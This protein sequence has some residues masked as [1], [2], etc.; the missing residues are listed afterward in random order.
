MP[1][2]E[3]IK[4]RFAQSS[5][6]VIDQANEILEEYDDIGLQI[7]LRQLYYQFVSRGLLENKLKNYKRLSS[8]I[9]DGR[10]AGLIDWSFIEDRTR[11]IR[12]LEQ[13]EGPGDALQ[14]LASW[15][16]IDFWKNQDYRPEVWIEKDALI[17]MIEDVCNEYDIPYFSCRGYGSQSEIW[18]AAMRMSNHHRNG[19]Q[20]FVIH[21]GDHD[22]SGIDMTRDIQDRLNLMMSGTVEMKRVA[23]NM[24]Q[25]QEYNP[26]PNPAKVTDSRYENYMQLYGDDSWELDALDP[27]H[28]RDLIIEEISSITNVDIW[29]EDRREM[30]SVKDRLQELADNW[31]SGE[32]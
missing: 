7:T 11:S 31:E 9:S 10:L 30:Q 28:F 5:L 2:I 19:Q 24:D 16:H 4:K 14:K 12:R 8:I 13:F 15:Y 26:P 20:P 17:N 1:K 32:D 6:D 27:Q 29:E 21:F 23:L 22:P 25:I 3:Y 18:R